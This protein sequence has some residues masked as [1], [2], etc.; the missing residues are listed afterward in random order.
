M[1]G[2][3]GIIAGGGDL[4]L[5]AV[6]EAIKNG[7]DPVIFSVLE[8]DYHSDQYPERTVPFHI[9]KI[10]TFLKLCKKYNI[11]RLLLLGKVK[12]EIIF[13]HLNFDLKALS[14]LARSLNRNDY[15]M[16]KVLAEEFEKNGI[17]VISQKTFLRPLL[18]PEGRYTSAKPDKQLLEDIEFGMDYAAKIASLDIGQTIVVKDKTVVAVEAVEG[19]DAAIARGGSL[20]GKKGAVVCKSAKKDQD[21]RFDLPGI[22]TSTLDVMKQFGCHTL[23]FMA[24]ETI[25]VNP[26]T[27]IAHAEKLKINLISYGKNGSKVLH[28]KKT[29]LPH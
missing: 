3:L 18:L 10:G 28:G 14:I 15:S 1:S 24:G 16:F 17:T 12:K 2:R 20:A 8:S 29:N 13:K 25:I 26:A 6:A 21:E 23:S 27:V 5:I 11:R 22:G 19:T 4:P 9:T 7:E